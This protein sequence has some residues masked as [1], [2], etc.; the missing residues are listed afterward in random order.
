MENI[1]HISLAWNINDTKAHA[2]QHNHFPNNEQAQVLL[3]QF[4]EERGDDIIEYINNLM[5]EFC[6]DFYNGYDND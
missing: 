4:F 5:A 1:Q 3:D 2:A 6:H